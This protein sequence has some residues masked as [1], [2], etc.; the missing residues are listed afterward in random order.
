MLNKFTIFTLSVYQFMH[1]C[2]ISIPYIV[3]LYVVNNEWIITNATLIHFNS[4][5]RCNSVFH[6]LQAIG[7]SSAFYWDFSVAEMCGCI[8]FSLLISPLLFSHSG[9]LLFIAGL[10]LVCK[11]EAAL[12]GGLWT[13]QGSCGMILLPKNRSK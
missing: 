9:F 6:L 4:S 11:A 10:Y 12:D 2:Y 13:E 8:I 3:S 5:L 7:L 1:N